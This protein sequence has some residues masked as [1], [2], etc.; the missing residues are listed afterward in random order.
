MRAKRLLWRIYPAYLLVA[1]SFL[2]VVTWYA[3]AALHRF[4]LDRSKTDLTDRAMLVEDQFQAALTAGDE[5]RIDALCK[6][7]GRKA[8]T[9]ITVIRSD[10]KV[11]GDTDESPRSMENHADRPE[12]IEALSGKAG[13]SERYS[14][15]LQELRLYAAVP[16]R[17][18]GK[19]VGVLRT[20]V[21]V[22]SLEDAIRAVRLR[23]VAI[24]LLAAAL[25]A[26]L[27]LLIS[28]RIIRPL[29]I[30]KQ[31]AERFARGDLSHQL[32]VDDAGEIGALAETL[33]QMAAALDDK[34]RAVVRQHNER[35][36][37]L[38]S[39]IEGVLAVDSQERLLRVNHAAAVLIGIDPDKAPGRMLQEVV[40]NPELEHLVS[41]VLST[42]QPQEKEIVLYTG[43]RHYLHAYGSVLRDAGGELGALVV[44]QEVT[45]L[46]RLEKI[47][48]DFVANVS[49]EL[50]TPVTSIK[51]FVE[52][53]LDGAMHQ[54][55]ELKRFL[56]I[57]AAQTD[58]LN[59][60]IE[61]LLTLSRLEEDVEKAEIPL[62]PHSLR[63]VLQTAVEVCRREAAAKN[64]ALELT[65]DE[66]LQ[67]AVNAPLLEQA[68]INLLDNAIKYS[69]PEQMIR[70]SAERS[71]GEVVLRVQDHGCGISREHLP[72]IFER[73]YRVDK[74]RSRRLGGTGLGLAI[75]KHIAQVHGGRATV[76]STPGQGST[77]SLHLPAGCGAPVNN[78][79]D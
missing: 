20:S 75:V 28:R 44:L 3:S 26:G 46:K 31:G 25:L 38:S 24:C 72:R 23:I 76:E 67:A 71:G 74:A 12:V 4:Y 36:A 55:E 40:R 6:A 11:L 50:R 39:M 1:L 79:A 66:N 70:L 7:L 64:I 73:F 59:A 69:P 51:G 34:I 58:R 62:A 57:V 2:A 41:S 52:T 22:R 17:R 8:A 18:D 33:N 15:T 48:R 13:S 27:S 19:I 32:H 47:R 77:F 30:L 29:E 9:R 68:I 43:G 37:I 53:L 49:H 5:K 63:N 54:P 61:D 56:Q 45:Q 60:I 14:A 78:T 42:R 65:C 10:G 16:L 35:E 21:S